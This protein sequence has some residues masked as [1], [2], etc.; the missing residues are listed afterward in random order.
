MAIIVVQVILDAHQEDLWL[1]MTLVRN[2]VSS[3]RVI[4]NHSVTNLFKI[5]VNLSCK[6]Q[7]SSGHLGK[8]F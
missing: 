7:G 6:S 4:G 8:K 5:L 2:T 3:H 1:R